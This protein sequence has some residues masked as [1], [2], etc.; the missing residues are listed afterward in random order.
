MFADVSEK[1]ERE[2]ERRGPTFIILVGGGKGEKSRRRTGL[3]C[4]GDLS[5][6]CDWDWDWGCAWGWGWVRRSGARL[7][8]WWV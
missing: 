8:E 5:W 2:R 6:D 1:R 4:M 3:D 7:G